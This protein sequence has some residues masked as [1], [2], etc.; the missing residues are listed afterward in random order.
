MA[1]KAEGVL[2]LEAS[3]TN[4][5]CIVKLFDLEDQSLVLNI[6]PNRGDCLSVKGLSREIAINTGFSL[7]PVEI[8]P[9]VASLVEQLPIIV[10]AKEAC[11]IYCGRV[12]KGLNLCAKTPFWMLE[13]LRRSGL[14]SVH[15][16]VDITN[17]VMLELGQ[18]L[19]A[20][21]LAAIDE[22]IVVRWAK[23]NESLVLLDQKQLD[24]KPNTLIIADAKNPIAMAGIMGGYASS[25]TDDTCNIFLECAYFA[26]H[27]IAGKAR[28]YGMHTDASHRFERGVDPSGVSTALE[29]ATQL[30]LEVCGGQASL[31]QVELADKAIM[32][33]QAEKSIT[34][35]QNRITRVIGKKYESE[36]IEAI[37]IGLGFTFQK[38]QLSWCVTVPSHRFDIER[39]EDL[40]EE[41]VRIDGYDYVEP[42]FPRASVIKPL[43]QKE[44]DISLLEV[45][46]YFVGREYYEAINYSFV[47][48][49][50]L[51]LIS[52]APF[53]KLINPISQDL[54]VM[55]TT[56]WAGLL[57]ALQ[58]NIN[59]QQARIRFIELGVC[60][61]PQNTV[62]VGE[63]RQQNL[64][65][66]PFIAGMITEQL[67]KKGWSPTVKEAD[68][69]DIKGDLEGFF[70]LLKITDQITFKQ[71]QHKAL[72]PG[73]SAEIFLAEE[74]IGWLGAL[75]PDLLKK[76]D[77]TGNVFL[78]ECCLEKIFKGKKPLFK[79]VSKFPT[80]TRDLAFV[81][82]RAISAQSILGVI[83]QGMGALCQDVT[84]FDAYEG[85]HLE[86][87]KKSLAVS[88]TLQHP[89]RTLIEDEINQV[90]DVVIDQVTKQF[91]AVLRDK[92]WRR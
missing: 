21:N 65:Q 7:T 34:L 29:R 46:D 87:S 71:A 24:L 43:R 81:I 9:I 17:F 73:Q 66:Q 33:A 79:E 27:Y 47:D 76:L 86:S 89:S 15:P 30:I 54:S 88:L 48:P 64:M 55:R 50:L 78:F 69:F 36:T 22:K 8:K 14:R 67:F 4:G 72:H 45:R 52:D 10:E 70:A 77:L 75:H 84:L 20:F 59:R 92:E 63:L 41:I 3:V 42:I 61:F 26:P 53:L 68:Y 56:L 83:K 1:E 62:S 12:I 23:E 6:T 74:S 40:I 80:V 82:D 16:V 91:D 35:R 51:A 19:H 85:E 13:K 58:N 49:E 39:E 60:F 90:I 28:Q 2:I 57:K 25:V 11:P 44:Q 37:L 31:V 5:A 38:T 32:N 18:P